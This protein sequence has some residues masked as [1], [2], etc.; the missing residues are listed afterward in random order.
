MTKIACSIFLKLLFWY[1]LGKTFRL[2][3]A[4]TVG[5]HRHCSRLLYFLLSVLCRARTVIK[6]ISL[7]HDIKNCR[8][9]YAYNYIA[10]CLSLWT[11]YFDPAV[12][13]YGARGWQK[14]YQ[15]RMRYS[16]VAFLRLNLTFRTF[17]LIFRLNVG[18]HK[19]LTL[20]LS[21]LP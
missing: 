11:L 4:L 8:I 14:M 1:R 20:P 7:Y 21:I 10:I 2:A 19:V 9:Q 16:A 18:L 17:I 5:S 15:K 12:V 13:V 6:N 3:M